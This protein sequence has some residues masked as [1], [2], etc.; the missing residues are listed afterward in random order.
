MHHKK[1]SNN[2]NKRQKYVFLNFFHVSLIIYQLVLIFQLHIK[3]NTG[4]DVL[5]NS[6]FLFF[7]LFYTSTIS[8]TNF[9]GTLLALL[10]FQ[11]KYT[12]AN[13]NI[14]FE[15]NEQVSSKTSNIPI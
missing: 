13:K 14:V 10:F 3:Y 12:V 6:P 1:I 7:L 15:Y 4:E 11:T 5:M 2:T 9:T 8:Q